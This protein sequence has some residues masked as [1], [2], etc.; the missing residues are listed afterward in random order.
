MQQWG[1]DY[2]ENYS[3]VLSWISVKSILAISSI[4]EFL[5]ISIDSIIFFYQAELDVDVLMELTLGIRV[6]GNR[7]E[8]VLQLKKSIYGLNQASENWFDPLK[9]GL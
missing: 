8:W 9:T 5:I 2:W 4:H 1:V 7:G 3:T 6:D